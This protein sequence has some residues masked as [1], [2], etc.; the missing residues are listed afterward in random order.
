MTLTPEQFNL[1]STKD[2]LE[3]LREEMKL[4]KNNILTAID[5][6]TKKV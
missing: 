5:N 1:L 2:D 3:R 4:D 6:L